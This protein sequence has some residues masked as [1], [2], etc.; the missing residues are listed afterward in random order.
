M[1]KNKSWW[2]ILLILLVPGGLLLSGLF[3]VT[4]NETLLRGFNASADPG[5]TVIISYNVIGASGNWGVSV[6]DNLNCGSYGT[7]GKQ[8]VI[9]SDEGTTKAMQ[10]TLPNAEGV[11]CYL[12]GDYQFGSYSLKNFANQT[13]STKITT[14]SHNSKA[15]YNNNVYWYN[16]KGVMEDMFQACGTAG[17]ANA[18]CRVQNTFAD[19]DFSGKIDRTELGVVITNWILGSVTRENLGLVIQAWSAA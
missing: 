2:I 19:T 16:S 10:Y 13:I 17:C 8:F 11:N 7:Q 18:V 4:G 6:I 14:I 5:A 12:T 9:I 1:T 15:C 3:S